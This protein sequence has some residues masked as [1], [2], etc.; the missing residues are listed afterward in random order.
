MALKAPLVRAE[1]FP[2]PIARRPEGLSSSAVPAA[3]SPRMTGASSQRLPARRCT[4]LAGSSPLDFAGLKLSRRSKR[5]IKQQTLA[6]L[7][8]FA[9]R[10]RSRKRASDQFCSSQNKVVSRSLSILALNPEPCSGPEQRATA[11]S[12]IAQFSLDKSEIQT[13]TARAT[14][15]PKE[16]T[17]SEPG[18]VASNLNMGRFGGAA[19]E[20][21]AFARPLRRI[22]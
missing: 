2:E 8:Q 1:S 7:G 13:G 6:R 3:L 14:A 9:A 21:K 4:T 20:P 18:R 15:S 11:S 17:R 5:K 22:D 12:T 16:T 19:A 10:C